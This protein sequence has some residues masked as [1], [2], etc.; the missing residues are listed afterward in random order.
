MKVRVLEGR[1][2]HYPVKEEINGVIH[3][4]WNLWREGDVFELWPRKRT[5][6]DVQT[7]KPVGEE[8]MSVEQQFS[9]NWMERVSDGAMVTEP[10]NAQEAL[11]KH[12]RE[13]RNLN[14]GLSPNAESSLTEARKN[15]AV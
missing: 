9:P 12:R 11:E 15:R 13:R 7:Q 6:L 3:E 5:I 8:V 4:R 10:T 1:M 14:A 2:G